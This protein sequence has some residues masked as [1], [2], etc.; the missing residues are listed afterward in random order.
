MAH[1][2]KQPRCQGKAS[3]SDNQQQMNI[4]VNE[5]Q[6]NGVKKNVIYN[7]EGKFLVMDY[8]FQMLG[9]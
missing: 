6:I 5:E 2:Q 1:L 4:V 9:F 3:T 8:V 7:L